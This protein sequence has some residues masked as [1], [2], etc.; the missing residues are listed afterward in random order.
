MRL[1]LFDSR[2]A[3]LFGHKMKCTPHLRGKNGPNEG[4]SS[5]IHNAPHAITIGPMIMWLL[6]VATALYDFWDYRESE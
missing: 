5:N 6:L 1:R 2:F 3:H 4:K